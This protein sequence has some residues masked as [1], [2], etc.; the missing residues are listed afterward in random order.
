MLLSSFRENLKMILAFNEIAERERAER[1]PPYRYRIVKPVIV[2]PETFKD[3][4]RVIDYDGPVSAG[5]IIEGCDAA[6]KA[7]SNAFPKS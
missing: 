3:A 7:F 2:A 6:Q 1:K 4:Q 5:L